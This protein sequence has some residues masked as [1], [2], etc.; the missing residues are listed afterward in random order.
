VDAR[1]DRLEPVTT[2]VTSVPPAAG[3]RDVTTAVDLVV[4]T[5][6]GT[7]TA[8]DAMTVRPVA[9]TRVVTTAVEHARDTRAG[10]T[11]AEVVTIAVGSC[12]ATIAA[13]GAGSSRATTV[14]R[15]VAE[16]VR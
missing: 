5:R 10:T 12:H 4:A 11:T 3:T 6:A 2:A 9:A 14:R 16:T 15:E 1:G 7:T 13:R 8:A